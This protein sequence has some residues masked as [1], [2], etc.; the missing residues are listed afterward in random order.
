MG[1]GVD[2]EQRISVRRRALDALGRQNAAGAALVFD[3]K[4]LAKAVAH[5]VGDDAC[6]RIGDAAGSR[7]DDDL[8]R[9]IGIGGLRVGSGGE[10]DEKPGGRDDAS[11]VDSPSDFLVGV[12]APQSGK[13]SKGGSEVTRRA[14]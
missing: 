5:A 9:A 3:D 13:G 4:G 10:G 14:D 7:G 1:G 12:M 8:D 2:V 11:H 6:R